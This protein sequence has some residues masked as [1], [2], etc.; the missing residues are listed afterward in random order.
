MTDLERMLTDK[1][2]KLTMELSVG[3]ALAYKLLVAIENHK[4]AK[5]DDS[6]CR[7]DAELWEVLL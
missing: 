4:K 2:A 6:H 7:H 3:K 5:W 1:V